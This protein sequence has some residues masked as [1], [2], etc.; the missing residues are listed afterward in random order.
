MIVIIS[1]ATFVITED[2]AGAS[3]QSGSETKHWSGKE[4]SYFDYNTCLTSC[5]ASYLECAYFSGNSNNNNNM[6]LL[7]INIFS[8]FFYFMQMTR[9]HVLL[10][11]LAVSMIVIAM[12]V[13][14]VFFSD[15][16]RHRTIS[17]FLLTG[18][19]QCENY[20]PKE[21]NDGIPSYIYKFV[22]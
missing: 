1:Y 14:I 12:L 5:N 4:S 21:N 2:E 10:C 16:K 3:Y 20:C 17:Y 11:S 15:S 22:I 9:I 8:M 7:F 13:I 6:I 19:D 18:C